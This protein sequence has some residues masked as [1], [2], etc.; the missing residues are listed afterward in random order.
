MRKITPLQIMCFL[1][2]FSLALALGIGTTALVF[3]DLP[4]GDFRG[5]FLVFTATIL[6]YAYV[7]GVYRLFLWM[8]P[9]SEGD[10]APE[11]HEEFIYHVY[12]LFCL[13]FFQPLIRSLIVPVPLMRVIYLA[14]GAKMGFNSYSGGALLDPPLT[15]MGEHCIIGHDAVLFCHVIEG[16]HL[17][18]ARIRL[19]NH[20][21]IGAK[22][23][24]MAGVTVDDHAIVAVNAVVL[25][26]TRIGPGEHWAG[27]PARRLQA[28]DPPSSLES[29]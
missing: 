1:L 7:I 2:L 15:E 11:S 3:G 12:L 23:V 28:T 19:G 20:V 27:I 25:K 21:T 14:L 6:I 5:V 17:A 9:L 18:L 10:I 16:N 8:T 4:L 22:A 24:L 13:I 29:I 26:G